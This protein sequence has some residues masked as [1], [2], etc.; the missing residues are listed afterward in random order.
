MKSKILTIT[1][2]LLFGFLTTGSISQKNAGTFPCEFCWMQDNQCR[3][4]TLPSEECDRIL[5]DCL[6]QCW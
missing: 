1:A 6:S 5:E 2:L 3:E 4:G